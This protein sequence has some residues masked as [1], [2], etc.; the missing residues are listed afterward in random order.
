[1]KHNTVIQTLL[2]LIL[3]ITA[4]AEGN[5]KS[6]AEMTTKEIQSSL[7]IV[8]WRLDIPKSYGDRVQL[9]YEQHVGKER[10]L[11]LENGFILTG[12]NRKVLISI[13]PKGDFISIFT[14]YHGGSSLSGRPSKIVRGDGKFEGM[15]IDL[16]TVAKV[17]D[18]RI[19]LAQWSHKTRKDMKDFTSKENPEIIIATRTLYIKPADKAQ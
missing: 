15:Y 8:A 10:V 11:I 7:G 2:I 4:S 9:I 3:S 18:D 12:S 5:I 16:D 1:M 14:K 13:R 17:E 19:I 6:D